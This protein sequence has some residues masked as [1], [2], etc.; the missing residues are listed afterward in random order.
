[1]YQDLVIVGGDNHGRGFISAIDRH[2]GE[3]VWRTARQNLR[4]QGSPTL[5][6]FEGHELL[7]YA[8]QSA[9]TCYNPLTGEKKWHAEATAEETANTPVAANG[10]LYA[11]GGYPERSVQ[12][13]KL[14]G[15][16]EI[17]WEQNVN[18]YVPSLLACGDKILAVQDNGVAR[19]FEAA[20]GKECGTR[21]LGGDVSASPVASGDTAI[22]I[23]ESGRVFFLRLA[24]RLELVGQT[25]L[26]TPTYAS[27]AI[28][29]GRVFI[30][31]TDSLLCIDASPAMRMR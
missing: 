5:G 25:D 3:L 18:D 7:L 23:N 19:L 31:T 9:L 30:R 24:K 13:I 12:A 15:S 17:V 14:D 20:T 22:V 10:L 21:R 29:R 27:P 16:G 1:L 8:G 26:G 4:S 2:S 11:T 28:A 6:T